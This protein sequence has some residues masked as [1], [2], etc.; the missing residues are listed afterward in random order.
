MFTTINEKTGT[1]EVIKLIWSTI[2]TY[3]LWIITH[4]VSVQ[5]YQYYCVP[6]TLLGVIIGPT[7]ISQTPPCRG[8]LWLMNA[9]YTAITNMWIILSVWLVTRITL[10]MV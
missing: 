6:N 8:I 5:L 1:S 7:I 9:S 2:G 3:I 4:W 10:F